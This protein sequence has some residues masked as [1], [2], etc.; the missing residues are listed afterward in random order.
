[1]RPQDSQF[2]MAP[3]LSSFHFCGLTII[4]QELH[5]WPIPL[6]TAVPLDR[7]TR[8]LLGH[9]GRGVLHLGPRICGQA[10]KE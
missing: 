8:A 4:W 6:A 3:S 9:G 1:M 5:F 10:G 7:A 2:I